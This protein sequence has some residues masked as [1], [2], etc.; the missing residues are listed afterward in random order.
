MKA[1]LLSILSAAIIGS[2]SCFAPGT[3][4]LN[5]PI[6]AANTFATGRGRGAFG[7]DDDASKST[8]RLFL[9]KTNESANNI[10]KTPP[11]DKD[12]LTKRYKI[13]SILFGLVSVILATMP[14]RTKAVK[15]GSK[16]AGSA[17]YGL[18]AGTCHIL[19]DATSN[20]RLSS[21]TYKRLNGGLF[22]FCFISL[23][24]IPGEAAFH[25]QFGPAILLMMAMAFM[26]G[27]GCSVAYEGWKTGVEESSGRNAS[28]TAKQLAAEFGHGIKSTASGIFRTPR[29]GFVY[30]LY[31]LVVLAGGFS[32]VMEAQFYMKYS[33]PLFDISLQWS[34]FARLVLVSSMV[35]SLKDAAE[36][37]R[38]TGTTF[39]QM[40]FMVAL[41]ALAGKFVARTERVSCSLFLLTRI[42]P[43]FGTFT[44][45]CDWSGNVSTRFVLLKESH[46]AHEYTVSLRRNPISLY[47]IKRA[48]T[49]TSQ[50]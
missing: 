16:Y 2:V 34:A 3:L 21:D 50:T 27:W 35:Y 44:C 47:E 20:D 29:K 17:G 42:R 33:A 39:I 48:T 38:L 8:S 26:K 7:D 36:R 12:K 46:A 14:D 10:E 49:A 5:P 37:G 28:V 9:S 1:L 15:L 45:S 13:G 43:G 6:N 30:L 24:A 40:N 22:F 25:P 32:A 31:L 41:W 18:A 23:F 4:R 11:P 19:A